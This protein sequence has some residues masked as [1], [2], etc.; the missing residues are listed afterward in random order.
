MTA[1]KIADSRSKR[2]RKLVAEIRVLKSQLARVQQ[3][4][5]LTQQE[6]IEHSVRFT[7]ENPYPVFRVNADGTLVYANPACENILADLGGQTGRS[8]PEQWLDLVRSTFRSRTIERVEFQPETTFL[9]LGLCLLTM[10][11]MSMFT[12]WI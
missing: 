10:R 11:A 2:E 9:P 1:Q 3:N 6:R 5:A 4:P 12:V 7:Q 8:L